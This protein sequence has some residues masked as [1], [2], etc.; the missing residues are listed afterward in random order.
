[1][2]IVI[3]TRF[4]HTRRQQMQ[5][6]ALAKLVTQIQVPAQQLCAQVLLVIPAW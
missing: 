6:N 1:M 2:V 4:V 5:L 3:Q